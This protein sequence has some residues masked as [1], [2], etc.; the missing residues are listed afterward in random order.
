MPEEF[1]P[2]PFTQQ[3]DGQTD[4]PLPEKEIPTNLRGSTPDLASQGPTL[5]SYE[6]PSGKSPVL[7]SVLFGIIAVLIVAG[8]MG[9][10]YYGKNNSSK[11]ASN[12]PT[13]TDSRNIKAI[14]DF[15]YLRDNEVFIRDEQITNT[16][17]TVFQYV[18]SGEENTIAYVQGKLIDN[19]G[20][21]PFLEPQEVYVQKIGENPKKIYTLIPTPDPN[22][23]DYSLKINDIAFLPNGKDLAITTPENLLIYNLNGQL[24]KEMGLPK[25][26]E[27]G[28]RIVFAF[29]DPRFSQDGSKVLL[30]KGYYEGGSNA[31]LDLSTEQFTDLG[32]SSYVAGEYYIDFLPR[33]KL[34]AYEYGD[35]TS[36]ESVSSLNIYSP[37][38]KLEKSYP[39]NRFLY[40][41]ALVGNTLY[42]ILSD[43][44]NLSG[45]QNTQLVAIDLTNGTQKII[46]TAPSLPD[47]HISGMIYSKSLNSIYLGL[48]NGM[49]PGD[50]K[51]Y[52]LNLNNQTPAF[53]LLKDNAALFDN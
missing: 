30:T 11:T 10:Y 43:S 20:G 18:Y 36:G 42:A 40:N 13:P 28:G 41:S 27:D 1:L 49:T 21:L 12:T 15:P 38:N 50:S 34:L 4:L 7:K 37:Q 19:P 32:N 46:A 6:K 25:E 16:G 48:K 52:V 2:K 24:L 29:R 47:Y 31:I 23:P 26:P 51:L 17:N 44:S 14:S 39:I 3:N 33:N 53:E 22:I 45:S 9:A 35:N 5:Q 8:I